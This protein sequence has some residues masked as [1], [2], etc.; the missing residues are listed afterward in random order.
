VKSDKIFSKLIP[1]G[2]VS[3][4]DPET[5]AL[6]P[7]PRTLRV[8]GEPV[9]FEVVGYEKREERGER[10]ESKREERGI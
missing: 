1:F 4:T 6:W 7:E 8:L 9:K 5:D 10:E 2:T 3:A